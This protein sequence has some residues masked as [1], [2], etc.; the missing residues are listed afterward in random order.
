LIFS[1]SSSLVIVFDLLW[2]GFIVED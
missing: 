2:S 1:N